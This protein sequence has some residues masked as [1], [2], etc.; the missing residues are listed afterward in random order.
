MAELSMT[1]FKSI[2]DRIDGRGYKAY[3]DIQRH[4]LRIGDIAISFDHV[5]GDPFAS[6]SV[7]RIS[8]PQ[9]FE[10]EFWSERYRRI[11]LEDM[12][13]RK[14]YELCV[15]RSSHR[16]IGSSGY[17][18]F[19]RP[20]Q[21]VLERSVLRVFPDRIELRL[22]VGLPAAGRRILSSEARKMIVEDLPFIARNSLYRKNYSADEVR[23][24]ISLAD[25]QEFVRKSLDR[26][27][28]VAF[29]AN[30]A[31]LPRRSGVD[32]RPMSLDKA[33]PFKSP[34]EFQVEISLPTGRTISGMGIKKGITLVA[35][36][37]YHGKST[38]LEAVQLGIYNHIAGDGREFVITNP[39]AVKI[40]AEDGRRV[41]SVDISPFI[42]ELPSGIDVKRFFTEDASGSTSMAA[43]MIEA[44]EAGSTFLLIDEDTAATNFMIRDARMQRLVKKEPIV[45]LID[46][47]REL[48][49]RFGV[50]MMVVIGGAGDYLDVADSVIMMED[51]KPYDVTDEAKV[52]VNE[53]P[54][55]RRDEPPFPM[56]P[57][58]ERVP[59]PSGF[60]PSKGKKEEYVKVRGI[61]ALQFGGEVV[62]LSAVETIVSVGQVS[63]IG[64]AM[65]KL[66]RD[67]QIDGRRRIKE[68][69]EHVERELLTGSVDVLFKGYISPTI[70][71]FRVLELASAINRLRTLKIRF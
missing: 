46:R 41:A 8:V 64:N 57:V 38:L 40:R 23:K 29:V 71:E 69:L 11:A 66:L 1:E 5:Q 33:V 50:S 26:L 19:P 9:S 48:Y 10:R 51:F 36:G 3:K 70:E 52:I 53:M 27:G 14:A 15:R 16:G 58:R 63:G 31:I 67:R 49:E 42:Y 65:L 62:D 20:G 25:E 56:E 61:G 2:L 7:F 34:P 12:I 60:D 28:L 18:G 21:E 13:T 45:P 39:T 43:N 55:G 68:I 54:T 22:F 44:I 4:S 59:L 30:G 37:G 35:G 24:K 17:I 47:A 32:P 6:P